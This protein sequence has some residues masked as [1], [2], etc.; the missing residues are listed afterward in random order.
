MKIAIVRGKFLNKYEMQYYEPLGV[1]HQLVAFASLTPFHDKFTF[2][3]VKLPSPMDLPNFPFK[4]PILNRLC[5]D[6][7]WLFGLEE[8]L[9]GFDIAHSAATY[10]RITWQSLNAKR[11][12]YVKKV[13][14]TVSDTIPFANE[15]IWGRK[16]FKERAINELDH[17]VAISKRAREALILEGCQPDKIT[18]VGH[19]IDTK[20]FRSKGRQ[21]KESGKL[22][23]LFVGRLE[24]SKG[25]YDLI[26]A[27]KKLLADP[28]LNDY[29]LTFTFVGKGSEEK[30]LL[31]F[32]KRLGIAHKVIHKS[33]SYKQI[34]NE[35]QQADIFVAPSRAT[36]HW[37]EYFSI[38]LLEAQA[39][40]LPIVTT[41]SGAIPENV[42]PA[43]ILVQPAD[44]YSLAQAIKKLILNKNLR[45]ALG[46]K[47][48]QRA[49]KLFDI[50][51]GAKKLLAV[52]QKLL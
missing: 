13:V 4:M 23:I 51:L 22:N 31:R 17:I 19:H 2:P 5:F 8:K 36:K 20:K 33:L 29:N 34:P 21:K 15:G 48:R 1:K 42:G 49:V 28:E 24:F 37:Q 32:E 44:F 26:F 46:K 52:Y 40:G 7:Q 39:S 41:T 18:V 11:K 35:Y 50:S 25:I 43:A 16:K 47:A 12:G 14:A 27:A 6:A 10:F 45:N 9:K 30:K 3:V 38:A